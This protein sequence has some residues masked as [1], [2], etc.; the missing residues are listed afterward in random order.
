MKLS[1]PFRHI[2]KSLLLFIPLGLLAGYATHEAVAHYSGII[3]YSQIGCSGPSCHGFQS[4]NTVVSLYTNATQIEAGQTYVFKFSVANSLSTPKEV[5]AGCDISDSG[6][7]LAVDGSGSGL[8]AAGGEL[9]HNE[10]RDFT[11]DSAV[12]Q[13]K[14]TAPKTPGIAHIYAVGNAVI[15]NAL[16]DMNSQFDHWNGDTLTLYIVPLNGVNPVSNTSSNAI[17][18]YPNPSH[19]LATLSSEG[20]SGPA[21]IQ[22]SDAAGRTVLNET[23]IVGNETPL[24]FSSLPNGSYFMQV[25]PRN[26]QPFT[27]SIIIQK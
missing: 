27:R 17:T 22:V 20:L 3:G 19:G 1:M 5:A 9:T 13:F 26:G 11:G 8:V 12:W 2:R 15:N 4:T 23:V 7:T 16:E 21:Q 6:G 24:D 18:V 10:P 14:Y 25:Q